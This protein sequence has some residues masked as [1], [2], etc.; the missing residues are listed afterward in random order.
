MAMS[1]EDDYNGILLEDMNSKFD[2]I[3]E[4]LQPLQCLP[5][6]VAGL[7][8]RADELSADMKVVKAA[9]TDLSVQVNDI[10]MRVQR[11]E[12]RA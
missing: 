3:M 2:A 5:A 6:Q 12:S 1:R 4:A 11:L 7:T 8:E 10:D 9:V